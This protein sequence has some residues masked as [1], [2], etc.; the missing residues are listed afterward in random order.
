MMGNNPFKIRLGSYP[1]GTVLFSIT[2]ALF[3]TGLFGLLL[4]LGMNVRQHIKENIQIQIYLQRAINDSDRAQ[5]GVALIKKDYIAKVEGKPVINFISKEQEGK[6]FIAETGENFIEFLGT[7]PLRDSYRINIA[8]DYAE[9]AKM[10]AIA[11]EIRSL[12]GVFEVSYYEPLVESVNQ[13]MAT[14]GLI[15]FTFACVL[16]TAC[17]VLINNTI[18]LALFSQRFL[19]RSMQLVGAKPLFIQMPFLKRAGVQGFISGIFASAFLMV[20]IQYCRMNYPDLVSGLSFFSQVILY[21]SIC[22][23]G[24]LLGLLSAMLAVRSFLSLSLDQLYQ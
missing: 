4:N 14:M 1:S 8:E 10:A 21:F 12:P 15:V 5:L 6:R 7:N 9:G 13:N 16:L 23:S 20:L 3:V 24:V 11:A 17:V 22:T 2:L 19:I 18:K